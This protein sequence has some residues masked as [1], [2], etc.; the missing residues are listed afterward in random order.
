M[1]TKKD[2]VLAHKVPQRYCLRNIHH[3]LNFFFFFKEKDISRHPI[4]RFLLE[5]KN[6]K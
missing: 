4:N 6:Q 3:F 5:K 1:K 2:L